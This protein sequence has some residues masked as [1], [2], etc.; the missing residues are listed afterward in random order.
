VSRSA[1]RFVRTRSGRA[2]QRLEQVLNE[3]DHAL[4]HRSRMK[5]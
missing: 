2:L 4:A 5:C 1:T 3:L